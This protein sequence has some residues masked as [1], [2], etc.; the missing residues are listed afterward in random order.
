MDA[1]KS[2]TTTRM[3]LIMAQKTNTIS[4]VQLCMKKTQSFHLSFTSQ[5]KYLLT[6]RNKK[7]S[8]KQQKSMKKKLGDRDARPEIWTFQAK[9]KKRSPKNIT[10]STGHLKRKAT[11]AQK[12]TNLTK[13]QKRKAPL[14]LFQTLTCCS[15]TIS[16]LS[17]PSKSYTKDITR[18]SDIRTNSKVTALTSSRSK[19]TS[20]KKISSLSNLPKKLNS[21]NILMMST[22]KRINKMK[23]LVKK[24][25][26]YIVSKIMLRSK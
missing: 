8:S 2:L 23:L 12:V 24:N 14:T 22:R 16:N 21:N 10:K 7:L 3:I 25:Q 13:T 5:K 18:S 20:C 4:L 15:T 1:K 9:I 6:P 19:K 17:R 11:E 26:T